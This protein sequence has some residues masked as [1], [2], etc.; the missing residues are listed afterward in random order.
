MTPPP[1]TVAGRRNCSRCTRWRLISDFPPGRAKRRDGTPIDPPQLS[2]WCAP[3]RRE[4]C[5]RRNRE[6]AAARDAR[7]Q[8]TRARQARAPAIALARARRAVASGESLWA[9]PFRDW[10]LEEVRSGRW[11]WKQLAGLAGVDESNLRRVARPETYTV[12]LDLADRL[13][14]GVGLTL[15]AVYPWDVPDLGELAA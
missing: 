14:L 9:S 5:R 11:E 1:V 2:A 6:R 10:I 7:R 4:D 3:C 8:E 13:L 12:S 15:E